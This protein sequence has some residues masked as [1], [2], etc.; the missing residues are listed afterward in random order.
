MSDPTPDHLAA[1]DADTRAR[2]EGRLLELQRYM[3]RHL[4]ALTVACGA[5]VMA[6]SL[7]EHA[8][9]AGYADA[10]RRVRECSSD[11]PQT[12]AVVRA[13]AAMEAWLALARLEAVIRE[14]DRA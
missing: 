1:L 6:E 14:Q 8:T 4:T 10:M 11:L 2:V 12:P 7:V 5:E 13:D 3:Q 9:P